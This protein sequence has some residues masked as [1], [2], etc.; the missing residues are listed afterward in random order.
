[1]HWTSLE[2]CSVSVSCFLSRNKLEQGN[3]ILT[4][5][6]LQHARLMHA[7]QMATLLRGTGFTH[8]PNTQWTYS[9]NNTCK[10]WR[11]N[12]W[13]IQTNSNWT[14]ICPLGNTIFITFV[15]PNTTQELDC[16]QPYTQNICC[17]FKNCGLQSLGIVNVSSS[18]A[19]VV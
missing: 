13:D 5:K 19:G 10:A 12:I 2:G 3:T 4:A 14:G 15:W 8:R 6:A 9:K 11:T 17:P 18:H 1:M 7:Q 16:L